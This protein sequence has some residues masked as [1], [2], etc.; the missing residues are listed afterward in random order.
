[1]KIDFTIAEEW[2]VRTIKGKVEFGNNIYPNEIE[3]LLP[4]KIKLTEILSKQEGEKYEPE[5][6]EV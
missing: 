3:V 2:S 5:V 4:L 1:V 6:K